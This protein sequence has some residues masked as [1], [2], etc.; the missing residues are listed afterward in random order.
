LQEKFSE[1]IAG[2][3]IRRDA[4]DCSS[5]SPRSVKFFVLLPSAEDQA[6]KNFNALLTQSPC[7]LFLAVA[8][9]CPLAIFNI[10]L[11]P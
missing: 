8:K 7:Y 5:G 11:K 6:T 2:A 10:P 4:S 9:P 1:Q 3:W